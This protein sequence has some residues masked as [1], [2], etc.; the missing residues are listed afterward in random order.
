[1]DFCLKVGTEIETVFRILLDDSKFDSVY[2]IGKMRKNQNINVYQTVIGPKYRLSDYKLFV[3]H[4]K[5]EIQPFEKFDSEVPE[6]FKIYSK[7]KHDNLNLIKKWNLR[8]AL[9]SLGALLI[10]I[11]NHPN[12]DNKTFWPS[13]E[14]RTEV[15]SKSDPRPRFAK[16]SIPTKYEDKGVGDKV[17]IYDKEPS[18]LFHDKMLKLIRE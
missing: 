10:L 5:K 7:Y 3:N 4:I 13:E 14:I 1:M 2:D 8:Y 9:F 6:W 18:D 11:T 17:L 15:F 12:L 16:E